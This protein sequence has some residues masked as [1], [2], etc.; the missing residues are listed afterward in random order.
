MQITSSPRALNSVMVCSTS[1]C[2]HSACTLCFKPGGSSCCTVFLPFQQSFV[3]TPSAC[4]TAQPLFKC[5]Q[6]N[7]CICHKSVRPFGSFHS[8]PTQQCCQLQAWLHARYHDSSTAVVM[9]TATRLFLF[10]ICRSVD[11][12]RYIL[13][14]ALGLFNKKIV[15]KNYGIFGKGAFPGVNASVC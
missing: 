14:T 13:S 2:T 8:T 1:P 5:V 10:F 12:H 11:S 9:G 15:G 7:S 4:A 6:K 3:D